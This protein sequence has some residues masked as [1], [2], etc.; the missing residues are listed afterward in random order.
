MMSTIILLLVLGIEV[1]LVIY[2]LKTNVMQNR[3]KPIV[4]LAT[5][6]LFALLL[7]FQVIQWGFQWIPLFLVLL[8]EAVLSGFYLVRNSPTPEKPLKIKRAILISLGHCLFLTVVLVPALIFPQ[9]E[10]LPVTGTYPVQ[11]ESHTL[12]DPTRIES[13]DDTGSYRNVTIQFWYPEKQ[14]ENETYPLILFSHGSFGFRG[15]NYST[16]MELASH[17]YVVGSIDHTYHAFFTKQTDD[18]MIFVDTNFMNDAIAI[19]SQTG[20]YNEQETYELTH[21]WLKLRSEDMN[22]VLN[23]IL[24]NVKKERASEVYTIIDPERIG[25]LGHSLGGATAADLGRKRMDID[26]VIVLDGTMLGEE[27]DYVDN[28]VILNQEPYPTPLLDIFNEEHFAEA[29]AAGENYGNMK[30]TKHAVD[31]RQVVFVG[32]GHLNFTDLPLFS[33]VLA[34]MLG[35]GNIDSR[36]CLETMNEVVLN[37]FDYYLKDSGGLKIKA[38][39]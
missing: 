19:Q 4:R 2:S 28:Q 14:Q 7:V 13:Y 10:A 31:A 37:Y 3:F 6:G 26:A 35:T 21:R 23:A 11:T 30:A 16:F 39:Y 5:F 25:L 36:Y 32:A 18:K 15:S 38:V 20:K 17:G 24:E 9:F 27:I 8:I 12:T 22:L 34:G 33:P 29:S 1:G